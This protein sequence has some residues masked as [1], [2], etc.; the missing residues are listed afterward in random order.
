M[1]RNPWRAL[2]ESNGR[3]V[4]AEDL[5]TLEK[6][7]NVI[8]KLRLDQVPG[9]FIGNPLTAAVVLLSLNPGFD[10]TVANPDPA[11]VEAWLNASRLPDNA[12]FF[13]IDVSHA[14]AGGHSWWREHLSVLIEA[15][16][17][18][19][20]VIAGLACIEWFPYPSANFNEIRNE[21][22]R[23][24]LPSQE[25]FRA[26]ALGAGTSPSACDHHHARSLTLA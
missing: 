6:Y 18:E 21:V 20:T 16:G 12:T 25:F 7:P 26:D 3:H 14:A 2:R 9:P 24:R 4:L 22:G 8:S 13:P 17:D 11:V 23:L 10:P 5:A 19:D 15:V 1:G